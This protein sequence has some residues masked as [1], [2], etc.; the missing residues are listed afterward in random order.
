MCACVCLHLDIHLVLA[1]SNRCFSFLFFFSE[2]TCSLKIGIKL[3]IVLNTQYTLHYKA[4][5]ESLS[6]FVKCRKNGK[7]M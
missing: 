3:Y 1:F 4:C 2:A 7:A 6:K 5:D